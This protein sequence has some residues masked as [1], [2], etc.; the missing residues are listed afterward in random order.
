MIIYEEQ[1]FALALGSKSQ[2]IKVELNEK[3]LINIIEM[4][5]YKLNLIETYSK[6]P[7]K[8]LK[9]N[10]TSSWKVY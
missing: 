8:C 10:W 5:K 9:N 6:I 1:Y 2:L 4:E 7:I 3:D